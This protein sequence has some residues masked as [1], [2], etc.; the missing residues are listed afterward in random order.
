MA[1]SAGALWSV[2]FGL[3]ALPTLVRHRNVRAPARGCP[4]RARKGNC[5]RSSCSHIKLHQ[6]GSNPRVGQAAQAI[7]RTKEGI[8]TKLAAIVERGRRAVAL[9]LAEDQSHDHLAVAPPCLVACG[10]GVSSATKAS[11]PTTFARDCVA[12]IPAS[13]SRQR[14]RAVLRR[15]SIAVIIGAGTKSKTSSAASNDIVAS[16]P[17][18]VFQSMTSKAG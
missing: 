5:A 4:R 8:N 18:S 7:G 17:R 13:A 6:D 9:G 12:N 11:T 16:A 15:P 10:S 3:D 14:V 1:R 2:G